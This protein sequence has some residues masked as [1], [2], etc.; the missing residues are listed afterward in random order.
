MSA[1]TEMAGHVAHALDLPPT[2]DDSLDFMN[3]DA[4]RGGVA[5]KS[6]APLGAVCFILEAQCFGD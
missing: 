6:R 4:R 1:G 3:I 5:P 2:P